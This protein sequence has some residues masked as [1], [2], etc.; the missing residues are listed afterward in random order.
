MQAFKL[1]I[2]VHKWLSLIVGLQLLIWLATGL[3][4]NLMDHSKATG[5]AFRVHAHH[6]GNL[7]SFDL[8]ATSELQSEPPLELKLVWLLQQPYY[9]LI[10]ERGQHNYQSRHSTLFDATTGKQHALTAQQVFTLAQD[11]YSGTG[12]LNTPVLA[13]PPFSDYVGQQNSM[14]M[15]AVD[16]EVNTTIY[17]DA[18]TGQVL[19]HAN[20]DSRLKDLMMKLHFM[21]Y[22]NSGGFNHWL[23]IVFAIATLILSSTGVIWLVQ[24]YRKGA[25]KFSRRKKR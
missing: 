24:Q 21:D 20:D 23:I 6:E 8:V 1:N 11:S 9:H 5:N 18:V 17:M 2:A 12:K 15:V 16:D 19:R 13:E 4:F 25:L 3:Y 10:Y 14:W 22:G 7:P